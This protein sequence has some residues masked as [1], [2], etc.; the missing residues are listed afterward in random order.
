MSKA[1]SKYAELWN[2][3]LC[4]M[5][6]GV[7]ERVPDKEAF[8]GVDVDGRE[9]RVTYSELVEESRAL[10]AGFA[11]LGLRRGDRVT[12]WMTNLPEWIVSY[13]ALLRIGVVGVPVN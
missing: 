2:Q 12:F 7:A 3:T 8:V 5:L 10:S 4:Q 13:F 11:R 1:S 9:R 6:T